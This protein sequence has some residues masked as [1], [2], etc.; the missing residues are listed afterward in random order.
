MKREEGV[1]FSEIHTARSDGWASE[2][3]T[4]PLTVPFQ[5]LRVTGKFSWKKKELKVKW[6]TALFLKRLTQEYIKTNKKGHIIYPFCKRLSQ[7][8]YK[9]TD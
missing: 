9:P 7:K 2:L 3:C 5:V 1:L 6:H 4:L 8:T